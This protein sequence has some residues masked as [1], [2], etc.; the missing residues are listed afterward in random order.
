MGEGDVLTHI[1]GL[2]VTNEGDIPFI[3]GEQKVFVSLDA[4]ITMKAKGEPTTFRILRN[5]AA[6]EVNVT[7]GPIPPLAPRFHG[8]DSVPDFVLIGGLVFTRGTVPLKREYLLARNNKQQC[9]FIADSQVW[10]YFDAYKEDEEHELVVLLT[11]LTHDVN[12]GYGLEHV[13]IL[14]TFDE[15]K[16]RSLKELARLY[17]E[18]MATP[19]EGDDFLRFRIMRDEHTSKKEQPERPDIVLEVA[20]VEAADREICATNQIPDVASVTMVPHL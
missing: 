6:M 12:I 9:P 4:V 5:G 8:Y 2:D 7:L 15:H 3:V 18:R 16:V 19:K 17:G 13:G 1:D 20:N 14:D 10:N 11:I